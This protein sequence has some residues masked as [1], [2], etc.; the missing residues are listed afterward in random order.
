MLVQLYITKIIRYNSPVVP[1]VKYWLPTK[2]VG[3]LV[4]PAGKLIV[5]VSDACAAKTNGA[6]SGVIKCA[7]FKDANYKEAQNSI[8]NYLNNNNLE[9]YNIIAKQY[10]NQN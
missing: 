7:I 10:P 9:L 3:A 8:L 6:G 1:P 5:K 4:N 2:T